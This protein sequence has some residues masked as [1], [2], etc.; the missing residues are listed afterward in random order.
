MTKTEKT[1]KKYLIVVVVEVGN[2]PSLPNL[3]A[4]KCKYDVSMSMGYKPH[5]SCAY[6]LDHHVLC[7][8]FEH[9]HREYGFPRWL[10]DQSAS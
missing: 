4:P 8:K 3:R 5:L 2:L 1:R 10:L 7:G 9:H 6:G